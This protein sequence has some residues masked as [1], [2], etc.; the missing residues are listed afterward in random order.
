MS[1]RGIPHV[2]T[3]DDRLVVTIAGDAS[4]DELRRM[5]ESFAPADAGTC[6]RRSP[7]EDCGAFVV[8][9]VETGCDAYRRAPAAAD[10]DESEQDERSDFGAGEGQSAPVRGQS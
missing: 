1:P 3:I 4:A 7:V 6:R 9:A 5:A 2:W 8:S 10:E